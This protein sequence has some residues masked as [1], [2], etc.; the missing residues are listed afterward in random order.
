MR[1]III[2]SLP[3][4]LLTLPRAVFG[5]IKAEK[6]KNGYY[7]DLENNK[8]EGLIYFEFNFKKSFQFRKSAESKSEKISA[9]E[10]KAFVLE[11]DTFAVIK[12]F[13]FEGSAGGLNASTIGFVQVIEVGKIN[14]YKHFST[15]GS[16]NFSD[17]TA[18][19]LI[20]YIIKKTDEPDFITIRK[21]SEKKFK[22]QIAEV[23]KDS[24]LTD[25]VNQDIYTW[26]NMPELVREYNSTH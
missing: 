5:Q 8:I 18:T 6:F 24:A 23:F 20:N 17:L 10:C 19:S 2:I 9:T 25:K 3:F 7:Y 1:A 15:Q 4:I 11:K 16:G 14:L 26:D 13:S 22:E 21:R 12:N